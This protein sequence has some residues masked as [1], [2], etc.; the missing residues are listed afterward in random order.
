MFVHMYLPL[1]IS[2]ELSD[3]FDF[4]S[5][6]GKRT[7]LILPIVITPV[8]CCVIVCYLLSQHTFPGS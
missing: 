2:S 7:L 6:L 5:F 1:R 3:S 8:S 4:K